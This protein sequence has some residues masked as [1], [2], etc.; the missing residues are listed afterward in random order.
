MVLGKT[1]NPREAARRLG[2]GMPRIYAL[3]WS[4]KLQATKQGNCWLIPASAVEA[5][6]KAQQGQP[7]HAP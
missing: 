4:G 2:V 1:L 6:L 3:L 7:E 5:R